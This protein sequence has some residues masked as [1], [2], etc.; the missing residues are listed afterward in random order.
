MKLVISLI[1]LIVQCS[2]G[3]SLRLGPSVKYMIFG[4]STLGLCG[5][6]LYEESI[7]RLLFSESEM[8]I[9]GFEFAATIFNDVNL[10]LAVYWRHYY[11]MYILLPDSASYSVNRR[12]SIS[13]FELGVRKDF[14]KFFLRPGGELQYFSEEWSNPFDGHNE[15]IDSISIGP[16]LCIGT[17]IDVSIMSLKFEMGLVFPN[18]SDIQGR[19]DLSAMVF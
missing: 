6:V 12:G 1:L 11:P 19:I 2:L 18:F 17:E 4:S 8:L 3:L 5:C 16:A 10:D 15:S 14:T 7:S 13:V 9:P